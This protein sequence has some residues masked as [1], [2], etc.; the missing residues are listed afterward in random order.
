VTVVTGSTGS[1]LV[2]Y[3]AGV[4]PFVL[5]IAGLRPLAVVVGDGLGFP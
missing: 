4:T 5:Y 1:T 2:E 3:I